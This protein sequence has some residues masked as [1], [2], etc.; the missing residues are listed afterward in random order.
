MSPAISYLDEESY[1]FPVWSFLYAIV[2][3]VACV[4]SVAATWTLRKYSKLV[5]SCVCSAMLHFFIWKSIYTLFRIA[6]VSAVIHQ[7]LCKTS[8]WFIL[9][10]DHDVGGFRFIGREVGT[11]SSPGLCE[12]PYYVKI[13]LFIGD[14]SLIS[15]AYWMLILVVE[16]LR[17]VVR[18]LRCWCPKG[19]T[20]AGR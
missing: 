13:C 12:P 17:L 20:Y 18:R 19:S 9:D 10:E 7:Y 5:S 15:G 16:L 11:G 8:T 14:A 2:L 4:A 1:P 3:G 6:V